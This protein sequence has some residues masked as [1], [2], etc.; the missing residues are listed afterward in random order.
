MDFSVI[1]QFRRT[2]LQIKFVSLYFAIHK[3]QLLRPLRRTELMGGALHCGISD[4][5]RFVFG[6]LNVGNSNLNQRQ[7]Q[8]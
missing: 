8:K 4:T 5:V 2:E 7:M 1:F 3:I 6:H